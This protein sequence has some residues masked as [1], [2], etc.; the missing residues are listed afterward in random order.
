MALSTTGPVLGGNLMVCSML[1]FGRFIV[2]LIAVRCLQIATGS[3]NDQT[4][5]CLPKGPE[6][7]V[8]FLKKLTFSSHPFSKELKVRDMGLCLVTLPLDP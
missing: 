1:H 3:Y 7:L 4:P 5:S 2:L 8:S 6:R